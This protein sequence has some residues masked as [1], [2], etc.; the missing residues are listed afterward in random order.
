[1]VRR[2]T[3]VGVGEPLFG[4]EWWAADQRLFQDS[5]TRQ[6]ASSPTRRRRPRPATLQKHDATADPGHQQE[7]LPWFEDPPGEP[8]ELLRGDGPRALGAVAPDPVRG[9][10]DRDS[11][12][13]DLGSQAGAR[14][15]ALADE[16]AGDDQPSEGY[17]AKAGRLGQARRQAEEIV[18]TE[19]VLLDPEP[20]ADEDSHS[21][22]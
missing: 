17:L 9:D 22:G 15:D 14:I 20:G 3:W 16:L 1:V 5:L 11:F 8:D 12:F 6:T 2:R 18:L 4:E 10:P 7:M 13:S 19:L 21:P